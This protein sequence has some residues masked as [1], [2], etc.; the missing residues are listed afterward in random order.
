MKIRI[1]YLLVFLTS[2][3]YACDE[4]STSVF[5]L[6]E[7]EIT[8]EMNDSLIVFIENDGS[9][10]EL[11]GDFELIEGKCEV[12]LTYPVYDTIPIPDTLYQY[13]TLFS[14]DSVY[15]GDSIF[16]VD[17]IF[18]IDILYGIDTILDAREIYR[19][20][21]LATDV[22]SIDEKFDRLKGEWVFRYQI[23]GI[24]DVEPSGSIDFKLIYN[25]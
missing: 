11:K 24:D 9:A 10:I 18:I 4:S 3:F 12:W 13:D 2:L 22:F 25:D 5:T 21:F 20:T 8:S 6:L 23:K 14:L 19:E 1:F 7:E 15:L 17:S 16:S